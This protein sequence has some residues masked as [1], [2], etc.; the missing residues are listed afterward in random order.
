MPNK[1]EMNHP[2]PCGSEKK[3]KNCYVSKSEECAQ[4]VQEHGKEISEKYTKI[5]NNVTES[6][7]KTSQDLNT[8]FYKTPEDKEVIPSLMQMIGVFT[9]IDVFGS[10]W[11]EY[12]GK[13][14]THSERFDEFINKF[15]FTSDNSE[16]VER[17][18][19]GKITAENLRSLRN[20][21]VHFY[22]LGKNH[23]FCIIANPSKTA[24]VEKIDL[25]VRGFKKY[26]NDLI[27]IQPIELKK[28]IIEGG[29]QMVKHFHM[30]GASAKSTKEVMSYFH[31]LGRIYSKL[32]EE[33]AMNV[34]QDM[35]QQVSKKLLS[36]E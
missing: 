19:L 26:K 9:V 14:G 29:V 3:Y 31:S 7:V 27:F 5:A 23:G 22:G 8:L 6:L 12:L 32:E 17:K 35:A 2:C 28:I 24:Q 11:F 1:I 16:F 34:S 13:H 20:S 10:Y 21:I 4:Y 36:L 33:G 18:Y 30:E 25:A 15:C